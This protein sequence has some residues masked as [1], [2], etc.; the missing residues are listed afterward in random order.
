MKFKGQD[1]RDM[2]WGDSESLTL[3]QDEIVGT[4]RWNTEHDVVFKF[5][6]RYY[7][8][9]YRAAVGD[10]ESDMWSYEEEVECNEVFPVEETITVYK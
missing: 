5:E 6:G 9:D 4:S 2:V 8:S 1:L 3:I 7:R 10:G